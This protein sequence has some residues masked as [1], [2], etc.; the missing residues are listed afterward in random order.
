M[1]RV[2]VWLVGCS[3]Q[4]PKPSKDEV[5]LKPNVKVLGPDEQASIVTVEENRLFVEQSAASAFKVNSVVINDS[6]TTFIR[7]VSRV[8]SQP[9][10]G[11]LEVITE[12]ELSLKLGP[13][14][15][16]GVLR[17]LSAGEDNFLL[18]TP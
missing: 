11:F 18:F 8:L 14:F 13:S 7:K 12:A 6:G 16:P 2:G 3:S 15:T 9:Q 5:V 1:N 17:S 4:P 10:T